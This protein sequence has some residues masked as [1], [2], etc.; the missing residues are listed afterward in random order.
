MYFYEHNGEVVITPKKENIPFGKQYLE[1]DI[2]IPIRENP[3][4]YYQIDFDKK[5]VKLIPATSLL[6]N[7]SPTLS[8][9][10]TALESAMLAMMGVDSNV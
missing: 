1:G 10:L 6:P 7:Y 4:D 8:D 3:L 2:D 9:R 5:E